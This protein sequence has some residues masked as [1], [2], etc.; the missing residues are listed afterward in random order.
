MRRIGLTAIVIM[1]VFTSDSACDECAQSCC[2]SNACCDDDCSECTLTV[3]CG[4]KAKE[5][6]DVE[7]K[8]IC[9]PPVRFPWQKKPGCD[10]CGG[11]CADSRCLIGCC[12]SGCVAKSKVV[13]VVKKFEYECPAL[14]YIWKP[15]SKCCVPQPKVVPAPAAAPKLQK[16]A[17]A[18]PPIQARPAVGRVTL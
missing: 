6:F 10:S 15:A 16:S 11:G 5:C 12:A 1:A 18:P 9:I 2:D 14:K 17:P 4:K 3:E 13:R 8:T 7:C